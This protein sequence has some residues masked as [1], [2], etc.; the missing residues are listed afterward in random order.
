MF[1]KI[2]LLNK[3]ILSSIQIYVKFTQQKLMPLV[4][5]Y[6]SFIIYNLYIDT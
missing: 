1:I 3:R 5:L 2:A 6:R 4:I